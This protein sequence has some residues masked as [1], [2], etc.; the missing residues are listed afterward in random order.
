MFQSLSYFEYLEVAG[1]LL[2][3]VTFV[4]MNLCPVTEDKQ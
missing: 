4:H 3:L 2:L 1:A